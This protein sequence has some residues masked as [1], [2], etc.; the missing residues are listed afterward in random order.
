MRKDFTC[1][2]LAYI[3]GLHYY[4]RVNNFYLLPRLE[5]VEEKGKRQYDMNGMSHRRLDSDL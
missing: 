3:P 5:T 4:T 1:L 2:G